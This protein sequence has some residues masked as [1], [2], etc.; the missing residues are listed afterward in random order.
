MTNENDRPLV[1]VGV[2]VVDDSRILLIRRGREPHKGQ[3]AVPGGKVRKGESLEQAAVREVKEET[4][5]DIDLGRVVW[6]GE[7]IGEHHHIVLIDFL[8]HVTGGA[9]AHGDD[10]AEAR[11]IAFDDLSNYDLTKTMGSLIDTLLG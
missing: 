8:G 4:G 3:W 7:D 10:A 2:A 1:G 9:L 5:L 11:W 6:V